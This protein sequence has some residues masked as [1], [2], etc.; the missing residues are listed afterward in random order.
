MFHE[1]LL[2]DEAPRRMQ[3]FLDLGGQTREV[4]R[5]DLG[6]LIDQLADDRLA[7]DPEAPPRG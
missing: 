3:R 7:D 4:E 6:P 2:D 5:R 1:T